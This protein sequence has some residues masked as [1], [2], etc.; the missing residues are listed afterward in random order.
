MPLPRRLASGPKAA[1]TA[2]AVG[3]VIVVVLS[4]MTVQ[5]DSNWLYRGGFLVVS[6]AAAVMIA[7][8]CHPAI[9]LGSWLAVAPLR[10][11]GTRSHG[12]YRTTGPSLA[13]TRPDQD[14]PFGASQPS[15]CGWA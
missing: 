12:L 2:V 11:I 15:S 7:L 5:E 13:V 6:G 9:A 1:L 4:F 10:Y 14:L 8:T 3:S